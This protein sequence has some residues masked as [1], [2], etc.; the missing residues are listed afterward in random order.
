MV[1]AVSQPLRRINGDASAGAATTTARSRPSMPKISSI[2]SFTSRPRSPIRPTTT[3]SALAPRVIMPN[4]TL[5][6][7]PEPANSPMRCPWPTVII[8]LIART[9][10]S[11]AVLM[12]LRAIGLMGLALKS[13]VALVIKG[14]KPSIG[15]PMPLTTRPNNSM[16]TGTPAPCPTGVTRAPGITPFNDSLGIKNSLSSEKP[17]TSASISPNWV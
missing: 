17:T 5:L 15:W 9:P 10:T 11:M 13:A 1:N 14:P 8:A 2:N 16:P 6:P 12:G 3:T 7:T 4:S